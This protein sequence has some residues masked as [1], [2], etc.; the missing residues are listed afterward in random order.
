MLSGWY[1]DLFFAKDKAVE[2]D[3]T[4]ADVHTQFTDEAGNDVGRI[5]HVATGSPRLMVVTVN[6]CSG[7]R[8]YAGVAFAYHQMTLDNRQRMNDEEWKAKLTDVSYTPP[9]PSWL[10]PA[11]AP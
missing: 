8:A 10:A 9:N 6:S 1:S 7:P 11:L 2:F 3:P 4:V 5:L